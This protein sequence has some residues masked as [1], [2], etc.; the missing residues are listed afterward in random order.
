MES[1]GGGQHPRHTTIS[2]RLHHHHD[3]YYPRQRRRRWE[4]SSASRTATA[5]A[6]L[7]IH[8]PPSL[9]L[10]FPA[11]NPC[12]VQSGTSPIRSA[13]IPSVHLDH[14]AIATQGGEA[15]FHLHLQLDA[16]CT[17]SLDPRE[18]TEIAGAVVRLGSTTSTVAPNTRSVIVAAPAVSGELRA[19]S[20]CQ[21]SIRLDSVGTL[22]VGI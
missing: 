13:P 16:V 11:P 3:P 9:C 1:H 19:V 20:M 2:L 15:L 17:A 21:C 12:L 5:V 6:R 14:V 7:R 4:E 18:M 10:R 8:T 22:L